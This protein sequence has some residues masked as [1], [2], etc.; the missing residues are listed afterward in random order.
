[1]L[2]GLPFLFVNMA[3]AAIL[4][5]CATKAESAAKAESVTKAE[6]AAKAESV[7]TESAHPSV[8]ATPTVPATAP[9]YYTV[10]ED[11]SHEAPD[12]RLFIDVGECFLAP[13]DLDATLYVFA[14][15]SGNVLSRT[16]FP[17]RC[18]EFYNG[19][20]RIAILGENDS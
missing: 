18:M 7:A 11:R 10:R 15:E 8:F 3:V 20:G 13:V 16:A 14:D 9:A 6:S 12:G 4:V 19:V 2:R 1:M 5:G 17:Y